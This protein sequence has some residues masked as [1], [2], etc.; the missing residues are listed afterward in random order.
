[1]IGKWDAKLRSQHDC[2]TSGNCSVASKNRI[3]VAADLEEM[4]MKVKTLEDDRRNL[5][6][7]WWPKRDRTALRQAARDFKRAMA[8]L[9]WTAKQ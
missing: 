7:P 3:S 1:A 9:R 2:R 6:F 8:K 5:W 4:P